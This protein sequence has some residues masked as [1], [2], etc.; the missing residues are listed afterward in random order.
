M[1]NFVICTSSQKRALWIEI[2]QT[3][4]VFELEV[5]YSLKYVTVSCH[6]GLLYSVHYSMPGK[7]KAVEVELLHFP[8]N[9]LRILY[10]RYPG[11]FLE[12]ITVHIFIHLKLRAFSA[13]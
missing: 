2:L 5:K 13:M 8:Q 10:F 4:V 11:F 1:T 9:T 3:R 12:P 7:H 6:G